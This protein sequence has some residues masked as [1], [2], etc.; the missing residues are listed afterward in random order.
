MSL[1]TEDFPSVLAALEDLGPTDR[2]RAAI[3]SQSTK[4]I[5][6]LRRR[7]PASLRPFINEPRLLRALLADIEAH[8]QHA[9]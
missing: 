2:A 1:K 8:H 9:A 7:L 6:R 3:L 5:E 4:T